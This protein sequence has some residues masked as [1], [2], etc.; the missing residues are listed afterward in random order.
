MRFGH[1]SYRGGSHCPQH[2]P[3][4][5]RKSFDFEK[6]PDF[7]ADLLQ[8][9]F[10]DD[11]QEREFTHTI[12]GSDILKQAIAIA[13]DNVRSAGVSKFVDLKVC[14]IQELES[15]PTTLW[16]YS[17]RPGKRIKVDDLSQLYAEIGSKLKK[18]FTGMSAWLI[19]EPKRGYPKYW[20]GPFQTYCS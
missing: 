5:Y 6:W 17:T 8:K 12:Y 9:L 3:G 11:S 1:F 14:P 7:D 20:A 16:S 10:E 13:E 2:C 4:I 19:V 18:D 15:L